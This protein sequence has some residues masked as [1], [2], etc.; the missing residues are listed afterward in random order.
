MA[1]VREGTA[2]VLVVVDVQVGVMR[3]AWDAARVIGHVARAVER[4]R[5]NS[6]PVI[7]VQHTNDELLRDSAAW[8]WVPELLPAASE[9]LLH[10][11]FNSSF[12]ETALEAELAARSASHIVLAGA[13]SNW[14]I[15][16][17]AYA[18][19]ERGYDLSLVADAH[20]TDDMALENGDRVQAQS[21]VNDLNAAMNWLR[22]PGRSNHATAVELLDFKRLARARA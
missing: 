20:T 1:S 17:T 22:Y 8:Q 13:S 10:K 11:R 16:A 6:V 2:G 5:E 3:Q 12:E 9:T 7:W 19:L 14:C 18:A 4:A 21:V 15:R